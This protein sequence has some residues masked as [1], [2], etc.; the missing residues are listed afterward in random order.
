MR[1]RI[2]FFVLGA[3]LGCD[4]RGSKVLDGLLQEIPVSVRSCTGGIEKV[5]DNA[6]P[7]VR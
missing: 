2:I 6:D 3:L 5:D 1:D 7:N 4:D